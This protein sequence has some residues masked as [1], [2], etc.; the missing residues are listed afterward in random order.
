[1][2]DDESAQGSARGC[3]LYRAPPNAGVWSLAGLALMGDPHSEAGDKRGDSISS[4]RRLLLA[5][6]SHYARL[7][8]VGVKGG[9]DPGRLASIKLH[10]LL[11]G[12]AAYRCGNGPVVQESS[13]EVHPCFSIMQLLWT[14]R[15]VV[16]VFAMNVMP[17]ALRVLALT[18]SGTD[19]I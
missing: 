5:G 6:D 10:L 9:P 15:T 1:M 2:Y 11:H 14:T 12:K 16:V 8:R 19:Y 17:G 7:T 3:R 18:T 4:S 13:S